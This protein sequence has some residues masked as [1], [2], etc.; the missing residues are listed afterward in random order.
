[1]ANE[2]YK[3]GKLVEIVREFNHTKGTTRYEING[4][5]QSIAVPFWREEEG[6][7]KV[8]PKGSYRFLSESGNNYLEI[9]N[10]TILQ[11]ADQFQIIYDYTQISS[12]YVEDFPEINVLV[13][14]YNELVEDTTK[15]FSYLKSV[16]MI[17]DTLQMTKVL[18]QLEP[19][20]TW[21]M[22][23][24]GE[25]KTLP[26]SELYNKF[27][28]MID[29]LHKEIK[30]LLMVDY[31]DM[32][33]KLS[34]QTTASL[35]QL[36]DKTA[37][38]KNDLQSFADKLEKDKK[39]LIDDYV[40]KTSK[41]TINN[42]VETVSK[43]EINKYVENTTKPSIDKYVNNTSK[44]ELNNY[45]NNVLKKNLDE[46]NTV[47]KQEIDQ[48]KTDAI[49]EIVVQENSTLQNILN[50]ESKSVKAVEDKGIEE[51]K[52]LEDM[53]V[54]IKTQLELLLQNADIANLQTLIGNCYKGVYSAFNKYYS[55]DIYYKKD[56]EVVALTI[57]DRVSNTVAMLIPAVASPTIS[58]EMTS[59][60]KGTMT[61]PILSKTSSTQNI[62][63]FFR[64]YGDIEREY[65]FTDNG[66]NKITGF[67]LGEYNRLIRTN[68]TIELEFNTINYTVAVS[69][70][71]T[72]VTDLVKSLT[73]EQ[74]NAAVTLI[75]KQTD[76]PLYTLDT[77]RDPVLRKIHY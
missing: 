50:A 35:K 2:D 75:K 56:T 25:I 38:L 67:E 16:G 63:K 28:Q 48:V 47:K 41:T 53:G 55:G 24:N 36:A 74:D 73:T 62:K 65:N 66:D 1:M 60:D 7:F 57:P 18:S 14:K 12:K 59:E 43:P 54:D 13:T 61:S 45:V 9:T 5:T 34:Q 44:P 33:N 71:N 21:Y 23:E 39:A 31:E 68:S 3:N 37:E 70:P 8:I 30:A 76:L 22:D 72:E 26:I 29:T 52:T 40:E 19:L 27:Q 6:K 17:A 4:I 69:F 77:Q 42:H 58:K 46:Y 11:Q 20:T 32:S 51:R 64:L 15:L 49:N 10:E